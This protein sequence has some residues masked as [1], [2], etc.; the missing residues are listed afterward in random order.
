MVA[1]LYQRRK[2]QAVMDR[3]YRTEQLRFDRACGFGAAVTARELFNAA[4][5]IDELLF[6]GKE[7][8]T[9]GT[10]ADANILP[11]RTGVIHRSACANDIGFLIVW[12]NVRFHLEKECRR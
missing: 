4:G 11:S 7:R 8:V 3:R 12:V 9:S 10:D 2:K 6:T 1:A 5:G